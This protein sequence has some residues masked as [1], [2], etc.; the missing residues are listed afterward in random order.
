MKN[1]LITTA[2]IFTAFITSAFKSFDNGKVIMLITLEVKN[3]AEWKKNFD[4]GA[5]AREKAGIKV[6]NICSAPDNENFVTVIEEAE[7]A[8]AAHDFLTLLK[9]KLKGGDT[10]APVVKILNKIQ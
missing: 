7:N 9:E 2:L 4:A 8:Q 6:L 5:P 1:I 3:F 10:S